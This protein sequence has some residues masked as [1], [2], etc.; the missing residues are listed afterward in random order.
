MTKMYVIE[1]GDML[2]GMLIFNLQP[3]ESYSVIVAKSVERST[4]MDC[5]GDE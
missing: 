3:F 4:R 5:G 2:L 1:I